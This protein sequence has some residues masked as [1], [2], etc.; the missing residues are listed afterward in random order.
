MD[1]DQ[2]HL[3]RVNKVTGKER[4]V[5]LARLTHLNSLIAVNKPDPLVRIVKYQGKWI[6]FFF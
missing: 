2:Q 3:E 1:R 4:T 5:I 6:G